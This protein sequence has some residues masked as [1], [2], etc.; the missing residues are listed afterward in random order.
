MTCCEFDLAY[1][2]VHAYNTRLL[3]EDITRGFIV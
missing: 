2:T 1:L 3:H